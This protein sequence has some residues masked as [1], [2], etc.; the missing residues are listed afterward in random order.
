M[1]EIFYCQFRLLR[2]A[3]SLQNLY[4]FIFHSA[5]KWCHGNS[6][7]LNIEWLNIFKWLWSICLVEHTLR[8]AF[9]HLLC[10]LNCDCLLKIKIVY[11][12][13]F[14]IVFENVQSKYLTR[15]TICFPCEFGFHLRV[16]VWTLIFCLV[17]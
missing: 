12:S 10:S 4:I 5:L 1:S 9:M 14:V 13:H 2:F 8:V 16:L 7:K 6:K 17:I 11:G 15:F 3:E